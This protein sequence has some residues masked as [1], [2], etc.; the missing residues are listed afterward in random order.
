MPHGRGAHAAAAP[1]TTPIT[2]IPATCR[3]P[4]RGCGPSARRARRANRSRASAARRSTR[5]R[6]RDR[7]RRARSRARRTPW[8]FRQRSA[9]SRYSSRNCCSIVCRFVT[10]IVGSTRATVS[11]IGVHELFG[12]PSAANVERRLSRY[13]TIGASVRDCTTPRSRLDVVGDPSGPEVGDDADDHRNLNPHRSSMVRPMTSS[14]RDP[15]RS[16]N[17]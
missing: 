8:R 6:R 4:S 3:A 12:R 17:R 14:G 15:K 16:A 1:S 13:A 10:G 9:R 5:A 11:R 7:A 2:A